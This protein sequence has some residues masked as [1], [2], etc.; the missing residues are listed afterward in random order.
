MNKGLRIFAFT[1]M[2]SCL[3]G[4]ANAEEYNINP[5]MWETTSTMDVTG[6]PPEMASMMQKEPKV[7][8]E[9]VKDKNYD[10]NPGEENRGCTLKTTRQSSKKLVWDI[11][12]GAESGNAKGQG[13][14]NFNGDTVS[15][16]FEMNM[17]G[18][19]GPMKMRHSFEGKRLGSC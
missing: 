4:V 2:V 10:F 8:K 12:C 14:A 1:L 15:G 9:C 3:V 18:P 16:W 6:M 17:Q 19:A 5:G 7:E 11:T 13:E